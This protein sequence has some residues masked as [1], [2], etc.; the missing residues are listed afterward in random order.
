MDVINRTH[1]Y[2]ILSIH[3]KM[4]GKMPFSTGFGANKTRQIFI[5]IFTEGQSDRIINVCRLGDREFQWRILSYNDTR[6]L[7]GK[8]LCFHQL[9]WALSQ[10]KDR[11]IYVL[12]TVLRRPLG[13]LIFNMGIAIPGKTVFLI[14][15][16][17]WCL[18][19]TE[20]WG[21]SWR[22]LWRLW[23]H[24]RSVFT[25]TSSTAS[26]NNFGI[27]TTFDFQ[28]TVCASLALCAGN[29]QMADGFS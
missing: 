20:V 9:I 11:L 18:V 15:T 12:S 3:W 13:R 8:C 26:D 24:R 16:A 6:P 29:P 22:Q 14:E 25:T 21:L 23:R 4:L 1:I 10:Y 7:R 17:P 27:M 28:R 2:A 19:N 5:K